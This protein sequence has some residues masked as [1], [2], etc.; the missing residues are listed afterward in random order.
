MLRSASPLLRGAIA[1]VAGAATLALFF[2]V[3]DFARGTPMHTPAFLAGATFG[4]ATLETS[5]SLIA[6]F[7][8][9]HVA[10][11]V[12][13]GIGVA[14]VLDRTG[15]RPHF[16]LGAVLGFLLF[17]V[18]F[19][20]GVLATGVNVVRALGWPG[21]LG[22]NLLAGVAVLGVLQ[23]TAPAG[24]P[25]WRDSFRFSRMM[26]EGVIAGLAG[27]AA[28]A[29]WF[30]AIDAVQGRLF[31]TPAALGSAL[32]LRV[33]DP[34]AVDFGTATIAT[35]TAIHLAA[36]IA[37][38][39]FAAFIARRAERHT[40]VL[41]GA[42]LLFVTLEVFFIGMIAIAASWLLTEIPWWTIAVA[43]VIAA[44]V[45]GAYLWREHPALREALARDS[46]EEPELTHA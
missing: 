1:G 42:A 7:T 45:M 39:I 40:Y 18:L 36:F 29:L 31:Y 41:L 26:R 22:G 34:G 6:L 35:F 2:F 43:N 16:L 25:A 46:L 24:T 38:G 8:L 20:V 44:G 37:I 33:Q 15:I 10:L 17:D 11:F 21:V 23:L 5:T 9:V 14:W 28:V 4:R 13:L 30:L 12:A 32:L 3:L 27:A 19:Y